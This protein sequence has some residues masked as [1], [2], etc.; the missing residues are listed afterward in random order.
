[1]TELTI[2][3]LTNIT[4]G[5]QHLTDVIYNNFQHLS[6]TPQLSH[7]KQ[8]ISKTLQSKNLFGLLV[9]N[10]HNKLVAYVIGE[11]KQLDD[12][13]F[14]YYIHY[15][16]IIKL[17]RG[18]KIGSKLMNIIITHCK[19]N[20]IKYIVLTCDTHDKKLT[21]FYKKLGFKQDLMLKNFKRHEVLSVQLS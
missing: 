10:L 17:Y 2:H 9:Y 5:T 15:I 19:N 12:S 21:T 1:M 13:R 16:Y 6:K 20:K 4:L 14:V 8:T 7:N 18:R 3:Q 11:Y